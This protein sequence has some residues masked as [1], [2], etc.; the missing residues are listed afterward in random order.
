MIIYSNIQRY[1]NLP[2]EDYLK[3]PGF[4]HSFLK[5]ERSGVA[6]DLKM[7]DNIRVGSLVD[8]ILTE[9]RKADMYSPLYPYAREI[10]AVIKNRFGSFIDKFQ[11]QVSFTTDVSFGDFT[12]PVKGRLDFLVAAMAVVDLKVTMSRDLRSLIEFMG[13]K[14][15]MFNYCKMP[16]VDTAYLMIYSVP[17]KK[18]EIIKVDCQG[19]RNA[20]WEEKIIKFG[21]VKEGVETATI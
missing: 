7:T 17:L 3:L 14:N 1:D 10:A 9:P 12:M 6:E 11:K 21:K 13:Y 15:Q 18:T 19:N 20:F 2:F 16:K 8:S 4:S 5:R